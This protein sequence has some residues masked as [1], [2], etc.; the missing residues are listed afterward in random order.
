MV[1]VLPLNTEDPVDP[2]VL[3]GSETHVVDVGGRV[4]IFRHRYRT[5]PETEV[6]HSVRALGHSE[7]RFPVGALNPDEQDVFISKLDGSGIE[8]RMDAEPLHQV[9]ISLLMEII[10]PLQRSV[11]SCQDRVLITFIDTI[12][13]NRDILFAEKLRMCLLQPL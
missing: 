13:L 5:G 12:P 9:R 3:M 11:V 10:S 4:A 7:E 1:L 6:V 2:S 8:G